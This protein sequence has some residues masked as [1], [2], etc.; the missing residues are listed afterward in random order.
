MTNYSFQYDYNIE[1]ASLCIKYAKQTDIDNF[2]FNMNIE[3]LTILGDYIDN[4][5]I[6]N[7]VK[8]VCIEKLGLKTISIPDSVQYLYIDNNFLKSLELP[9]YIEKVVANNNYL[10][11]II[12]KG[13]L[14][15][16]YCLELEDNRLNNLNIEIPET[17]EVLKIKKNPIKIDKK[18]EKII[19]RLDDFNL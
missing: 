4:L 8:W 11:N 6:P 18:L 19:N 1:D 3:Y 13:K 17:I 9:I 16:L 14:T 2:N 12:S 10:E 5:I 7:G 15:K